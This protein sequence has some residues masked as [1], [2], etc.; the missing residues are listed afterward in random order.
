MAYICI[1]DNNPDAGGYRIHARSAEFPYGY[2]R[3]ILAVSEY[4]NAGTGDA[5][6]VAIRYAP[7]RNDAYLFS[8][9]LRHPVVYV[10][11][12]R[13]WHTAVHFLMDETEADALFRHP[14]SGIV[15][16]VD[17]TARQI[18]RGGQYKLPDMFRLYSGSEWSKVDM[19]ANAEIDDKILM[20]GVSYCK[21]GKIKNQLFLASK[22][23]CGEL[24][25]IQKWTPYALRKRLSF[26]LGLENKQ[27]ST[28]VVFNFPLHMSLSQLRTASSEGAPVTEKYW[29][30]DR[31]TNTVLLD[32]CDRILSWLDAYPWLKDMV[33]KIV[34]E[35]EE[36]ALLADDNLS[37]GLSKLIIKTGVNNWVNM[38]D[39][40]EM[41]RIELE[42]LAS[43]LGKQKELKPLRN[44]IG[45]R[46]KRSQRGRYEQRR[47]AY[48]AVGERPNEVQNH[49]QNPYGNDRDNSELH[50]ILL[51]HVLNAAAVVA[52]AVVA[53][54]LIT[55]ARQTLM[56]SEIEVEQVVY[57][58]ISREA[59]VDVL[60][61]CGAFACGFLAAL[62]GKR[63]LSR[64]K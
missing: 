48:D 11:G 35:W 63:L 30:G 37:R 25:W 17:E 3:D 12:Q 36:L 8:W 53:I 13:A 22:D 21:E 47:K 29:Y 64:L 9:I 34:T 4:F 56:A 10:E 60:K 54:A 19:E 5:E 61:L 43:L 2:E 51:N 26:C 16:W 49:I 52:L 33:C 31:F 1:Y 24:D 42:R 38:L 55:L 14:I 45:R 6:S 15:Q 58:C 40:R 46:L 59:A 23:P 18:Y 7:L 27:E 28:G 57:Y 44:A 41:S 39:S 62:A 20:A 32:N 50:K